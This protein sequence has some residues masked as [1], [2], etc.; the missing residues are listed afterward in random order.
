M[1]YDIIR[2]IR[3]AAVTVF[4]RTPPDSEYKIRKYKI[5]RYKRGKAYEIYILERKRF[6]CLP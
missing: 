4:C 3:T 1:R 5:R 2:K 6:P